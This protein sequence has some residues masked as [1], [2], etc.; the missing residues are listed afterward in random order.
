[1]QASDAHKG[2]DEREP[3]AAE[4]QQG[5]DRG[6]E[7]QAD[8]GQGDLLGQVALG[9]APEH[10]EV[11]AHPGGN[12]PAGA[13]SAEGA[14]DRL[15]EPGGEPLLGL[16]GRAPGPVRAAVAAGRAPGRATAGAGTGRGR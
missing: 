5:G 4:E 9:A 13:G 8:Q 15:A 7:Q 6:G 2:I 11:L 12:E 1:M 3:G 10:G 14:G 16:G